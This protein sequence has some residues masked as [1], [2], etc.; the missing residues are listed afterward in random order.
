MMR[1]LLVAA[2]FAYAGAQTPE[3][4]PAPQDV[5]SS[6]TSASEKELQQ[7]SVS[8][9]EMRDK[10]MK[11]YAGQYDFPVHNDTFDANGSMTQESQDW[12]KNY[13]VNKYGS[14]GTN[15]GFGN[16][17]YQKFMDEYG[18]GA[19]FD[20]QKYMD[21]FTGNNSFS[22]DYMEKYASEYMPP[23]GNSS[24]VA[25]FKDYYQNKFM[26]GGSPAALAS[27]A[28][29]GTSPWVLVLCAF[30]GASIPMA[31]AAAWRRR[32][33]SS[34]EESTRFLLLA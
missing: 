10:Y 6:N 28:G 29:R 17:S 9:N 24:G 30:A 26:A 2:L 5:S 20:Y 18:S 32:L 33:E 8:G 3:T 25:D 13:F 22:G 14:I 12:Y 21:E 31:V 23:Q 7:N 4:V 19:G 1:S 15:G 11:Q 34:E 16:F 27:E